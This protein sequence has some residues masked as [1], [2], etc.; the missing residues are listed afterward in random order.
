MLN[1]LSSPAL[2]QQ[3]ARSSPAAMATRQRNDVR[4]TRGLHDPI[5][6]GKRGRRNSA[7]SPEGHTSGSRGDLVGDGG[8]GGGDESSGRATRSMWRSRKPFHASKLGSPRGD[9]VID[10]EQESGR[11]RER[12]SR[13]LTGVEVQR[14][15]KFWPAVPSL[16]FSPFFTLIVDEISTKRNTRERRTK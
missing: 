8:D 6:W 7:C 11:E 9:G 10:D 5:P 2:Q 4:L 13:R 14:Q 15:G 16:E 1:D 3:D 12:E